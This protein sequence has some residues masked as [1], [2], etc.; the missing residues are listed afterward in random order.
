M[1]ARPQ[2]R[3]RAFSITSGFDAGLNTLD[4]MVTNGGGPSGVI[5]EVSG[6]AAVIGTSAV[7]EP[8]SLMLVCALLSL[9]AAARLRQAYHR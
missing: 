3:T 6:T 9:G 1:P 4:F 8:S 5:A 2:L 7:P